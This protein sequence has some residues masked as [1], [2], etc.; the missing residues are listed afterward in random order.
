MAEISLKIKSDFQQ[1]QADFKKLGATSEAV[2]AKIEKFRASFKS[3]QIDKFM[4]KNKLAATAV[5]A[6]QGSMAS[7]TTEAK[8]LQREIERLIKKGMDPQDEALQKMV[9]EY[10]RLT[11]EIGKTQEKSSLFGTVLGANLASAAIQKGISMIKSGFGSIITEAQKI[12]DAEAAFTPLMGG[13]EQ[14]AKMIAAL[15][16]A[17]A[18][19]PFEFE[20][21]SSVTK[22][23]L[24][25]MN[26]D[27]ENTID[28]M[29]MLGDTAGG[30]AQ[31]LESIT[32]GYTK[33]MLKNKVDMESLNMIAE[34]GV[35]IYSELASSMGV[36]VTEMMAMSSAG[37]ITSE[38]LTKAFQKMTSEGGI[39]YEGMIIASKTTSGVLS[40][41]S[42]S[43]KMAA[44]ALGD[45]LLP[46]IKQAASL[47]IDVASGFV[48][49]ATSGDNL[50]TVLSAIGYTIVAVTSGI[51]AWN[52]SAAVAAIA[53]GTL[54]TTFAGAAT[55]VKAFTAALAANPIGLIVTL[56]TA[57]LVPAIIY[58]V[59]N[60]DQMGEKFSATM[61]SVKY[62]AQV[63]WEYVKIAALTA[64]KYIIAG[65][66]LLFKP[67]QYVIDKIIDAFNKLTGKHIPKLSSVTQGFLTSIDTM[68]A[69]N[70]ANITR[71]HNA[72]MAQLDALAKKQSE[73]AST[74]SAQ[75]KASEKAQ[76]AA[77]KKAEA[78]A[79]NAK[80]EV[81]HMKA[82][83]EVMKSAELS[84]YSE[85]LKA[86]EDF[87]AEKAEMEK[88]TGE[89]L[90]AWREEQISLIANNNKMTYDEQMVAIEALNN[91]VKEQQKKNLENTVK[92]G[93]SALSTTSDMLT[94]LQTVFENAGKNSKEL[95][96]ALR[97]VS[98]AE[99]AINSYLAFTKA[100]AAFPPPYNYVAA[101]ATLAAGFAKQAA[102]LST[103]ISS[104]TGLD[105]YTVPDIRQYKND[106][107]PVMAQA[108]ETVSVTPRGESSSGTTSVAISI[109]EQQLFSVIQKGINTGKLTISSRNV[110]KSV[111]GR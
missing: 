29:K 89:D 63:G 37:K 61:D 81:D 17:A 42:D 4:D 85:R 74:S 91:Y 68:I 55:A 104:E 92:F 28:T 43:L 22:Q 13:A 87:F 9:K 50:E 100:L 65:V 38:D 96:I 67:F 76:A 46:Y 31:K 2:Q 32:R 66:L 106:S 99:A 44:A 77:Q 53:N 73:A 48:K 26:G 12:E 41:M 97:A 70:Q 79:A 45:K 10:D 14:A 103:P 93:Q 11:T 51:I 36:S 56:I 30:N 83:L 94:D 16:V 21:L 64:F 88:V 90:A 27:I 23:L 35:P 8:G 102:I 7:M 52:V 54:A 24:P 72:R 49:W 71:L 39:F 47:V 82:A 15:N 33:A 95:A 86:A 6:T 59:K 108:G 78:A 110:G 25:V 57:V 5:K 1:A 19:T 60:W 105:N 40:T 80:A 75:A 101:G 62:Y 111:F 34:A 3:D 84:S 69:K 109:G 98:A 20:N 58:L 18:E 107:Y